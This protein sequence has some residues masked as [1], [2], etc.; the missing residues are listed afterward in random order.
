V[1]WAAVLWGHY[2]NCIFWN[3]NYWDSASTFAGAHI[4]ICGLSKITLTC[5]TRVWRG[6]A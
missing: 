3:L 2:L 5:T 6:H 1:Y 4:N